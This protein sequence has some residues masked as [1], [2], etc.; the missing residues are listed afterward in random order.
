MFNNK[1]LKY[2]LLLNLLGAIT[3]WLKTIVYKAIIANNINTSQLLGVSLNLTKKE[4][5]SL[6]MY[7]IPSI[8][9]TIIFL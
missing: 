1:T 2:I 5:I 3:I 7:I 6:I 8:A 9:K 4:Y